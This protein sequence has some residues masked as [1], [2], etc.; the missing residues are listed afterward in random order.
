MS[1]QQPSETRYGIQE[2]ADLGGVTRRTVRYYVRLGLLPPP[3]GTGRGKHYSQ[4]HVDELP[5]LPPG[6]ELPVLMDTTGEQKIV[7]SGSHAILEHLEEGET[8]ERLLPFLAKDRAEAKNLAGE[9]PGHLHRMVKAM[10]A[11]LK[12]ADALYPVSKKDPGKKILPILPAKD[13]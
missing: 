11:A 12:D 2:L 13:S 7:A 1:E 6:T 10:A 8:G 5:D 3:L 9:E 4:E